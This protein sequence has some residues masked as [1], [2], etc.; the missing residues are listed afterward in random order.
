MLESENVQL[1]YDEPALSLWEGDLVVDGRP[2]RMQ[3]IRVI[4]GERIVEYR[5]NLGPTWAFSADGVFIPASGITY[6]SGVQTIMPEIVELSEVKKVEAWHTVG[7]LRDMADQWRM[8]PG[9]SLQREPSDLIQG[10]E[11]LVEQ[12]RR[13]MRDK[14]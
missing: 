10:Y 2:C 9:E 3:K 1:S 4:R 5:E 12:S 13:N 11:T 8:R 6:K 7:E 14:L